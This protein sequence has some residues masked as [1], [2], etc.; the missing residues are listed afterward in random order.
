MQGGGQSSHH[1]R[2]DPTVKEKKV[3]QWDYVFYTEDGQVEADEATSSLTALTCCV[4]Q[5][6]GLFHVVVHHRVGNVRY[7][8]TA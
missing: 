5:S 4:M 8:A 1:K 3:I 7:A 2:V 6:G